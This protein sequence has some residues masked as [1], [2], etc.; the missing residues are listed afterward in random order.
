MEQRK[1][2]ITFHGLITTSLNNPQ[3]GPVVIDMRNKIMSLKTIS[4]D[5]INTYNPQVSG[6]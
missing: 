2:S 6:K 3:C 4:L 5:P 1:I